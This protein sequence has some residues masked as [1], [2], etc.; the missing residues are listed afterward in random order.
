LIDRI[1]EGKIGLGDLTYE[2]LKGTRLEWR[3]IFSLVEREFNPTRER[4]RVKRWYQ[5]LIEVG[6]E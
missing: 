4:E 3:H 6:E 2:I 5:K 1:E